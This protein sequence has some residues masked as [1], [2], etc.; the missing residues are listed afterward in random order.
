MCREVRQFNSNI[1]KW[2]LKWD[3]PLCSGSELATGETL[4]L[5]VLWPAGGISSL[6]ASELR[7]WVTTM[8][9]ERFLTSHW[10]GNTREG[11]HVWVTA[12]WYQQVNMRVS[13]STN[14]DSL[15]SVAGISS[16]QHDV[17]FSYSLIFFCQFLHVY[18][19]PEGKWRVIFCAQMHFV[20]LISPVYMTQVEW[21]ETYVFFS[22]EES[23]VFRTEW[24]KKN[25]WGMRKFFSGDFFFPFVK[26]IKNVFLY[27]R[28]HTW[29]QFYWKNLCVCVFF[30]IL[31]LK[32]LFSQMGTFL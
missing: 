26:L 10:E 18:G 6:G 25:V 2:P 14:C 29:K 13:K 19:S 7:G 4:S 9:L 32:K 8:G 23:F 21:R 15:K 11:P 24:R 27:K 12:L 20:S 17:A 3:S 22:R 5:L 1:G 16:D 30:L 31:L 28:F